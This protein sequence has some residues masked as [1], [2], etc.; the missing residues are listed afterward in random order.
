MREHGLGAFRVM[1]GRTDAA[2]VRSAQHHGASQP[3]LGAVAQPRGMVHQLIDA[4][5]KKA[6]ELDFADRLEPL[7]R[8]ADAEPADQEL[9]ER[10]VDHPF[11]AEAL[12]QTDGG[13]E[14]AAV[15]ADVL[16]ENDDV[17]ILVHGAG[18]RQIDGL[19]QGELRH[20]RLR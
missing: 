16:A 8:H 15:D 14:D 6:H 19:D 9:G 11:R 7:R 12:L 5:I 3:P 4:G 10:R 13:A 20:R 18:E 2:A 17:G 1:F